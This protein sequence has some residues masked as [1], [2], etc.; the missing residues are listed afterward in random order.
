MT[1]LRYVAD[2]HGLLL[3]PSSFYH[4]EEAGQIHALE[5]TDPPLRR[6]V[7]ILLA[8]ERPKTALMQAVIPLIHEV[9]RQKYLAGHWRGGELALRE[10]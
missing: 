2:G 1:T 4:L 10:A 3:S 5:I 6:D 7:Y 8:A 9:T